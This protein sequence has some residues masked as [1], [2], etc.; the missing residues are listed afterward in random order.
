MEKL[1]IMVVDDEQRMR[2]LVKDFLTKQNFDVIEAGDGEEAVDLFFD[3]KEI[4]LV[5]L[6]VMMPKIDGFE[7]C[8][9]I[10]GTSMVPIIMI[11]AKGEDYEKIMGLD[12]GADDYIV[13][14]F[15][16]GEIMA[17]IRAIMRR[18]HLAEE[19]KQFFSYGNLKID[20]D[21]LL[22][23]IDDTP[24]NLTKKEIELLWQMAT[25]KNRVFTRDNLLDLVWGVDYY[26]DTRTVDTHIKRLRAKLSVIEHPGWEIKTVWGYGYK[27]EAKDEK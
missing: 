3:H 26:G 11:T 9:Q 13:K 21:K 1:K 19:G 17:R 10:R 2:I 27:F 25:R 7:V 5:I 15:S 24:I 16:P 4:A 8:K 18:I 6:D 20:L 23:T 22:V 14:P 12:I